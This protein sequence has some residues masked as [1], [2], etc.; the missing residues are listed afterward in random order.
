MCRSIA[1][2]KSETLKKSE[3][4]KV[5]LLAKLAALIEYHNVQGPFC[6][7][8]KLAA[9]LASED[10]NTIEKHASKFGCSQAVF[11]AALLDW[12]ATYGQNVEILPPDEFN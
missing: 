5:E 11:V 3:S 1:L 9:S 6:E 10:A 4:L 7:S 8:E 2:K 12:Y